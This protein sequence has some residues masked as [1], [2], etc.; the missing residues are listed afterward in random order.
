VYGSL[1]SLARLS[2][3]LLIRLESTMSC[4]RISIAA[5][6]CYIV[7]RHSLYGTRYKVLVGISWSVT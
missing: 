3:A 6:I 4:Y 7:A 5:G 2:I 1:C